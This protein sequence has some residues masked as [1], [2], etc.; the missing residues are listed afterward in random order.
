M[1]PSEELVLELCQRSFLSLWSVANPQGKES[2]KELC[3]VL[4]VCDPDIVI[5]SVKEIAL[6]ADDPGETELR[7]WHRRAVDTSAKQLYGA[8]RILGQLERIQHPDGSHAIHLPPKDRRRT[9]RVVVALGGGGKV[10]IVF[11]DLGKGFVNVFDETSLHLILNELD[12]VTDFV[13]YLTAKEDQYLRSDSQMVLTGGEENLLAL[14]LHR[15]RTIP[16]EADL[17]IVQDGLWNELTA[18]PEW[19]TRKEED[20]VSY[21]WDRL[22]E[23][24]T[25]EFVP[26]LVPDPFGL[27]RD[28]RGEGE[29]VVRTM[30]RENRFA[31][32][33]LSDSFLEFLGLAI[34]GTHRSRIVQSPSGIVYVLLARPGTDD[35]K[36]RVAELMVRCFIAR[37][38][39][40]SATTVVGIAT[41]IPEPASGSSFDVC[42]LHK[43]DWSEE[44]AQE[45]ARLQQDTGAFTD[46]VYSRVHVDEF[47]TPGQ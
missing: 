3:D 43:P 5:F 44:D 21:F 22:I 9:H 1:N 40:E 16:D 28:P 25:W 42:W 45:L 11:G 39:T 38:I 10:P 34:Q 30:A 20:A 29:H 15:G 37:G 35:R 18:K 31:R 4:V 8:E 36:Q 19:K 14:Y 33:M 6:G 17:V 47:P 41:E 26:D 2:G 12:T 24:L 32:R 13:E 46:P 23:D 27:L 7:R